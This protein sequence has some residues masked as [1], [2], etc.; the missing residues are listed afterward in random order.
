[1]TGF[2]AGSSAL[3]RGRYEPLEV[4][5][6]GAQGRVVK[7]LDHL[8]DRPVALKV[9]AV[10]SGADRAALLSEARILF[11]LP[12]SPHL[13]IAR[14]DFFDGDDYVIVM[15]WVEGTNLDRIL[16][17]EGRPGLPPTLVL[18]WLADAAAALTHLHTQD[19]PVIHGDIKPA[20]LILTKG[21][22]VSLVDFGASSTPTKPGRRGG[23]PGFA[24]PER[25][26]RG[27]STRASDIYSLAA[28]AFALLTGEPPT[29]IRPSWT[30][31]DPALASQLEMAIREGLVT[32]PAHRVATPG[33]LVERLRAGWASSLP[34]GVLTFCFTDIVGSTALWESQPAAMSHALVLHDKTIATAVERRGGRL[35]D[36]MAEGDSTVSVF[37]SPADAVAAAI[38]LTRALREV[39]WP[40][41]LRI[42][43]RAALHT[44]EAEQRDGAFFGLTM[45]VTARLRGLADGG[46]VFLSHATASLVRDHLPEGVSLVDLG[47]ARL[48][49][50]REREQVYAVAAPGV[51]APPPGTDCPYPG[52]IAFSSAD[53]DRYFG[54]DAVVDD[55]LDRLRSDR[56]VTV[57]GASG[58]GKS[59][60]LQAG[61]GARWPAGAAVITPGGTPVLGADHLGAT[62]RL[63]IVDQFEEL[64][65]IVQSAEQRVAFIDALLRA[66]RPVAI[67]LRAD[68][69]GACAAHRDLASEMTSH[70]VLLGPMTPEELRVAIEEPA[71]RAG[72][73]LEPGLVDLLLGEVSGEP[74]ELPLLAHALR[75][76]WEARDGRTLTLDAYRSTGGVK[77]A[78][79]ATADS[80]MASFDDADRSVAQRVLLRL[81]EP[82]E[83]IEDTR[84]RAT[85]AEL[86]SATDAGGRVDRVIDTLATARMV[87]IDAAT[88]QVAHE[89]LIREW[90]QLRTWLAEQRNDLRVQR[91]V[92]VGA[93]AWLNS[94]RDPSELY[95]GPRLANALEWLQRQPH[96]S[97]LEADFLRESE[98]EETRLHQ[99]QVR[100]NRRL[101]A[102]LVG[103]VV[104]L[105]VALV[106]A[107]VAVNQGRR[108]AASRDHA[109][110]ARVA[111]VSRSLVERQPDLGLL[112]SVEAYRRE[113]SRDTRGTLLAALQAHP[114]LEGLIYGAESG[115]EAAAFTP[116]GRM[117][118]TPTSDG[119]GTLLWDTATR[120][121]L[122]ALRHGEDVVLDAAISPDGRTL[123]AA[124][125][126]YGPNVEPASHLQVWDLDRRELA[127][128]LESPAG[129]L[130]S[131]AYSADGR[132]VVTQG[133]VYLDRPPQLTAVVWDTTSWQP[134]GT[135]WT[136]APGYLNDGVI[137]VSGDGRVL[138]VPEGDGV[139]TWD[140]TTRRVRRHIAVTDGKV[141]ALALNSDG[142]A[143]AIGLDKGS[144]RDVDTATGSLRF[145]AVTDGDV[146]PTAMEFSRDGTMLAVADSGGR[147]HLVDV[148]T[149]AGLGP[150]LAASSSGINDVSFSADG[151]HLATAGRDRTGAIWRLD[152]NRAIGRSWRD[153][154]AV[155]TEIDVTA[156]GRFV[157]SGGADGTV[158]VRDAGTGATRRADRGGE[159]LTVDVDGAGRRVV[160]GDTA[161]K[162]VVA[163]LPDLRTEQEI[164]F[165][166]A[167]VHAA[168]F[169]PVTGVVAV[170]VETPSED[171]SA[172]DTGFGFV[173]LWDPVRNEEVAPRIGQRGG[174]PIALAWS[175]DGQ[176]VAASTD[177]NVLRFYRAGP[178]YHQV[179]DD[180]VIQDDTMT[181]LAISP[182]GRSIAAGSS[183]G[184]VRQYDVAT[185]ERVGPD[186]R[187][188]TFEVGGVAYSPDG[189]LLASTTVGLSTTRLWEAAT[190]API[191]NEL[192]AGR[193]PYTQRTFGID[194]RYPSRPAFAPDGRTLFTPVVD[195]SMVAWDLRPRS[196]MRAACEIVGRDL[197]RDEWRQY[198]G[199]TAY[200]KTCSSA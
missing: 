28:T 112:L 66:E 164:A 62:D 52:L 159:V 78:I 64:F 67:G 136:L 2:R 103:V 173:A 86:R 17:V 36:A 109:E 46:Q 188:H 113:D 31:I 106:G 42:E 19:P 180:L 99:A 114:L 119:S 123:V 55:L 100:A 35:I 111:A 171:E 181:A 177:N 162:V 140:V 89:A 88:V 91:Q 187:G 178:S 135:P 134:L 57:I 169:N 10:G 108:A 25:A 128:Y 75:A 34:T 194:H 61:L 79:A 116:D 129:S 150:A 185:H 92:T 76:T 30:G 200:R 166:G 161:G 121:P 68:F 33:E 167:L 72:L 87:S 184:I 125:V 11:G 53:A 22:R 160:S 49:S 32:D 155:A 120:R 18:A 73:R 60:L 151:L 8:H 130:T 9:R 157:V 165:D 183:S 149:G 179:G 7:A 21:G 190:G 56:I 143:V 23:T 71:R 85:L 138:A 13:P 95:R 39:D 118:A 77:G 45:N 94:G 26:T 137:T 41:T 126:S 172:R 5:G 196:W 146:P 158:T 198:L 74:G 59:S 93:E 132:T 147:T 24:A 84:R 186:L 12:P 16:H 101:R 197:T 104:A 47:P 3:V 29:G 141:T 195:G 51:D 70:Q 154:A 189:S 117:L 199:D 156:D 97:Q 4:V 176:T 96:A 90:P 54:R 107:T 124:T 1:M 50:L 131:A 148:A 65:S 98:A 44:G 81:V 63:L 152:G 20:N 168:A 15:D 174:S 145:E 139:T 69:Y 193:T 40:G 82:G 38:D 133:G 27:E 191:G 127:H 80:T 102:S 142:S 83:G 182:D 170:A 105:V 153:H 48:R 115:L 175:P 37:A 144:V 14:D 122:G 163:G 43:T 110:V 6:S 58:S 192:V